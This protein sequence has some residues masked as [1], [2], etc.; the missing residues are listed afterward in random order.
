MLLQI[1]L[2]QEVNLVWMELGLRIDMSNWG[3]GGGLTT[4]ILLRHNILT[5]H[6]KSR[7]FR[8]KLF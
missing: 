8:I 2:T 3:K 4:R 1:L 7:D 5:E 6:Y